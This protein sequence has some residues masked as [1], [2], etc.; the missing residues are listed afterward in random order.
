MPTVHNGMDCLFRVYKEKVPE[1]G[2]DS[3]CYSV[4]EDALLLG[5][6]DG[7]G[8]SGA[9]RYVNYQDKTGAYI[10]ARAVA[11]AVLTWFERCESAASADGNAQAIQLSIKKRC[12][13]AKKEAAVRAK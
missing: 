12:A 1:N 6:F 2:E 13:F 9:K 7:C 10:A 11:G 4:H 5:V 3:F 8:G